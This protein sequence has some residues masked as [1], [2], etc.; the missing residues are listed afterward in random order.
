[1]QESGYSYKITFVNCINRFLILH[2]NSKKINVS[3]E[4]SIVFN[5][6]KN[7]FSIMKKSILL[8][9]AFL[10]MLIIFAK[11]KLFQNKERK[12][13]TMRK[14]IKKDCVMMM[15]DSVM[16][17]MT[18]GK[19]NKMNKSMTMNNGTIVLLDGTMTLKNGKTRRLK[20]GE[21]IDIDGLIT[22]WYESPFSRT[23]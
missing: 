14:D 3:K 20:I 21:M 4:K 6:I 19:T 15:E 8:L 22:K 10:F 9:S 12:N 18:S 23:Y 11:K 7:N 2:L 17:V 5:L 13:L 16:I 1:M